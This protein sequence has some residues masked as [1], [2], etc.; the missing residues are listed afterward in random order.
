MVVGV[1][2]S[3]AENK[4]SFFRKGVRFVNL[5]SSEGRSMD[6]ELVIRNQKLGLLLFWI[7]NRFLDGWSHHFLSGSFGLVLFGQQGSQEIVPNQNQRFIIQSKSSKI[8]QFPSSRFCLEIPRDHDQNRCPLISM[9][10][11]PLCLA[12]LISSFVIFF[13]NLVLSLIGLL[14]FCSFFR[15][16]LSIL[17]SGDLTGIQRGTLH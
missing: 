16:D 15:M 17:A 8:F 6:K 5:P 2:N 10:R 12:L 1:F 7:W 13:F 14:T 11:F 4:V 3:K 9:H